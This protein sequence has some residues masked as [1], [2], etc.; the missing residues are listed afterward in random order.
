[1]THSYYMHDLMNLRISMMKNKLIV[2]ASDTKSSVYAIFN[3]PNSTDINLTDSSIKIKDLISLKNY[4]FSLSIKF[5]VLSL[6]NNFAFTSQLNSAIIK[7]NDELDITDTLILGSYNISKEVSYLKFEAIARGTDSGYTYFEKYPS[8]AVINDNNVFIEG[9]HGVIKID[10]KYCLDGFYHLEDNMI[11][12]TNEK[13]K[14]YY[15]DENNKIF[16]A[17]RFPCEECNAPLNIS[18]MNCKSC[19]KDYFMIE[20]TKSCYNEVIDNYYLD[21]K[22]MSTKLSNL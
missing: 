10:L 9:R 13:P 12:C 17:C 11:L 1:M 20:E 4:F 18:Y 3:F 8:D 5:K 7:K 15:F 16:R 21:N 19:K 6:P 14:G 2:C 22:K